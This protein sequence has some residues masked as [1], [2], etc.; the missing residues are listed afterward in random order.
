VRALGNLEEGLAMETERARRDTPSPRDG[1]LETARR[2]FYEEGI[3]SVGIDRIV[4][5]SGYPRATIYRHY[6]NKEGLVLAYLAVEDQYIR[7]YCGPVDPGIDPVGRLC[8]IA[9]A[10]S[11]DATS[12]HWRG[13]P[14]INAAAEFPDP[15]SPVRAAVEAHRSWFRTMLEDV[16]A[17][18]VRENP[19]GD[20]AAFVL[21]RDAVL[22]GNSLDDRGEANRSF[23]TAVADRFGL[24]IS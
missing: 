21:L 5:E 10:V 16:F 20:A 18:A 9:E 11:Q 22:V 19:S 7:G 3:H 17:D 2:L 1:V 12:R 15:L 14:F 4:S 24:V 6:R 8:V 23:A 13:C